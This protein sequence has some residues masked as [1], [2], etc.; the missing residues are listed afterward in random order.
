MVRLRRLAALPKDKGS[1]PRT[2]VEANDLLKLQFQGISPPEQCTHVVH[3]HTCRQNTI[4]IVFEGRR[5]C[6][7]KMARWT[8]ELAATLDTLS[9]AC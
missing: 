6:G 7:I 4:H 9:S 2:Y 1:I 8:K 3:N 5:E